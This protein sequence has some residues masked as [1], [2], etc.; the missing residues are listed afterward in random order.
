MKHGITSIPELEIMGNPQG[1]LF[2]Y[3]SRDANVNIFAVGDQ[4][5]DKGWKVNRNQKPDGL[6]AMV[7]A[8]HLKAVDE[9]LIDLK[10]AVEVVKANP[11]LANQGQAATY[12]MMAH[13]PLRGMIKK[14]VLEMY[15]ELYR[16][17]GGSIDLSAS[18]QADTGVEEQ[19]PKKFMDRALAWYVDKQSKKASK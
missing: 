7:T 5:D 18:A 2:A 17:G 12:G 10:A 6:H 11:E 19:A 16:A 8:Q 3:K 4:M 15:S 13:V 1:P 9:Y 14:K